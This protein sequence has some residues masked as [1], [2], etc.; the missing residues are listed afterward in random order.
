MPE[1]EAPGLSQLNQRIREQ[2][3]QS[4]PEPVWV[5]AEISELSVNRNGHCYLE[6]IEK[7]PDS[8]RV[9]AG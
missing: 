3:L 7:D 4:F 2:I 9:L 5:V 6:L 8:D 1:F